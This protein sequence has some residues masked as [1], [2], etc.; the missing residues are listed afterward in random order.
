MADA[1]DAGAP[2]PV[3]LP[4]TGVEDARIQISGAGAANGGITVSPSVD[5]S[6]TSEAFTYTITGVPAG[7]SF[8]TAAVGGSAVGT[9]SGG[10]WTFTKAQIDAGLFLQPPAQ[11][12]AELNLTVTARSDETGP[13][14]GAEVAVPTASDSAPFRVVF[15]RSPTRS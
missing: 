7:Y 5:A 11:T 4:F 1:P 15:G 2:D 3:T 12:A 8:H 6:D 10:I 14:V 13:G 9:L